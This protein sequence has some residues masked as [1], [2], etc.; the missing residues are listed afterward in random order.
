MNKKTILTI[1]LSEK[2][3]QHELNRSYIS[4]FKELI[5]DNGI[6]EEVSSIMNMYFERAYQQL[7]KMPENQ[8]KSILLYL[9]DYIK[10]RDK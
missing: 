4:D 3:K 5:K 7:K 8:Y 10:N 6:I 1:K 2:I 9:T